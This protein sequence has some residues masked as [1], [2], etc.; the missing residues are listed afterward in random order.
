[1]TYVSGL[2]SHPKLFAIRSLTTSFKRCNMTLFCHK[3]MNSNELLE[4]L[5]SNFRHDFFL[6]QNGKVVC[7]L[8]LAVN[9]VVHVVVKVKEVLLRDMIKRRLCLKRVERRRPSCC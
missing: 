1:M 2:G 4:F 6:L 5:N 7:V 9:L 3:I 8:V